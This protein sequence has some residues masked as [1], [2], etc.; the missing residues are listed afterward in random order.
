MEQVVAWLLDNAVGV[1]VG[2]VVTAALGWIFVWAPIKKR[3]TVH[4]R[5]R[6]TSLGTLNV[7]RV[8]AQ[9]TDSKNIFRYD[10]ETR[11][12][13]YG[14]THGK[15]PVRPGGTLFV[16]RSGDH[17]PRARRIYVPLDS[18]PPSCPLASR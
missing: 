7:G 15:M 14:T 18:S 5:E 10:G 6:R 13:H 9:M 17:V 3:I 2:T 12:L 1:V 11:T 16:A 4:E 8:T